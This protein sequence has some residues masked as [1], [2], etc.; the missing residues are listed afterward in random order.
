MFYFCEIRKSNWLRITNKYKYTNLCMGSLQITNKYK[1]TNLD[2]FDL[3]Y[4]FD[5]S[6]QIYKYCYAIFNQ[7]PLNF[8]NLTRRA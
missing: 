7:F 5:L 2:V 3:S 1:Y 8:S 4:L 6:Q